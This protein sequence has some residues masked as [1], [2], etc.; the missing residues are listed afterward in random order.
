MRW[1]SI[2]NLGFLVIGMCLLTS[3]PAFAER[4]KAA[5]VY[6]TF[7]GDWAVASRS[8][9][10]QKT[11]QSGIRRLALDA[12]G[13]GL[14][15]QD[16]RPDGSQRQELRY[17]LAAMPEADSSA[18][19]LEFLGPEVDRSMRDATWRRQISIYIA[20]AEHLQE[21]IGFAAWDEPRADGLFDI[22][23]HGYGSDMIRCR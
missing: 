3:Q 20:D 15:V 9:P 12:D 14:V 11:C 22:V 16:L 2:V 10:D 6:R 18:V 4:L 7:E 17:R 13:L 8:S 1:G 5:E 23:P 19:F 21:F